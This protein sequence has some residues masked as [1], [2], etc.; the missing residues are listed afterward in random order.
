MSLRKELDERKRQ[1]LLIVLV[2]LT[3]NVYAT[4]TTWKA[5]MQEK[6]GTH[7]IVTKPFL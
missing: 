3:S 7:N 1:R 2:T 4:Y 5:L 6:V